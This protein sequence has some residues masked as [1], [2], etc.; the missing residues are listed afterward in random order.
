MARAFLAATLEAG[1][2]EA[3]DL[4]GGLQ[5]GFGWTDLSIADGTRQDGVT[6]YL[7]PAMDRPNL[8]VVTDALVY[9][10]ALDGDRCTGVEYSTEGDSVTVRCSGEVV[11]C[12]GGG[13]G[14]A[15][16]IVNSCGWRGGDY[17]SVMRAGN[18]RMSWKTTVSWPSSRAAG[19]SPPA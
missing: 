1:Y 3:E 11:L 10:V 19:V 9:R 6:A 14:G 7:R 16:A 18:L 13:A 8:H 2:T 5:E 15:G 17:R 12:A 4:S